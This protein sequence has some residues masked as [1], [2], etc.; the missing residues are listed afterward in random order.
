MT[1]RTGLALAGALALALTAA[2]AAP[3]TAADG[4]I[5][6]AGGPDAVPD[7]YIVVFKG[8][9]AVNLANT[10]AAKHKAKVTYTYDSALR[11]FAAQMSETQAKK[12][13]GEP[14]VAY[15]SQDQRVSTTAN[16][17]NPPSW[18]LDR[19]D[20][21][22]RPLNANYTYNTTASNVHAYIVDTGIRVT[23]VD[24][25]GRA[26]FDYNAAGG[27]NTDCNGHGTHVA[28]TVGGAA[29]GVAK[30]VRL[31]A[32][33]VLDCNGSG[34]TAGVIAGVNW[35][36]S[37]RINPAVANMSLGGGANTALDSAV[38]NSINSGVTYAIAAGNS[39]SNACG[40]SPARVGEALTVGA[41]NINDSRSS[42]SNYGG[43]LDLF[44]PGEGI[45]SAWSS[46]DTAANTISGTSMASPHVAGV[47]ALYLATNPGANPA[48][49]RYHVVY[50]GSVN[51]VSNAGSGSPNILLHSLFTPPAP[52]T[53]VLNRGQALSAGQY[54]RSNVGNHDL[55]MQG[56][57]NFVQYQGGLALW[58]TST[59]GNPGAFI[60]LQGDGNLV[61]YRSNGTPIW[62]SN[63]AGT[64]ANVL[65]MQDRS[66]G[67]RV[68]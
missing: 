35:V 3:A 13:A 46:S 5:R 21:R 19:I 12:V 26:T 48:T 55:V 42:F 28:G 64:A 18:G 20:Q 41:T 60:V 47:A 25:G 30:A 10:L 11:G 57:G 67:G 56:D 61:I 53:N 17:A 63:T 9:P 29:Y 23:H 62:A 37:N 7:S 8:S 22:N 68:G 54:I 51:R 58:H 33:K 15:V 45:T 16:Q 32:V 6:D 4:V 49:V 34:T 31:H 38:R 24:F 59:H 66:E 1:R 44:A 50:N 36:T 39:N 14:S 43:C 65:V 27:A 2:I 40:F 52:G